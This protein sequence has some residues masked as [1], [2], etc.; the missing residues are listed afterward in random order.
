MAKR[1]IG[2]DVMQGIAMVLVVLGHHRFDF[3]PEWYMRMF[4]WIYTFHMPLFIFI[5]GFLI[6]Y[7]YKGVH[8]WNEY[9]QYVGKRVRKFLPPYLIVGSICTLMAWDF[10]D[11]GALLTSWTYLIISPKESEVT[12]L[13]YIY[14][15]LFFYCLAPLIFNT[16]RWVRG[17]L[18]A[19]AFVMSL[20]YIPI[21]YLCVDWFTRYFIFFL[22]GTVVAEHYTLVERVDAYWLLLALV[23]FIAMSIAHFRIG[24][25]F[26]LEYA[27]QWMGIPAFAAVAWLLKQWIVTRTALVYVSVNCFGV[28]LL[29]MFFVQAGA[30]VVAHLPWTIPSWGYVIYLLISAMVSIGATAW[31]WSVM[32]R[33]YFNTSPK[34]KSKLNQ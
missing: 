34:V 33:K 5:S 7:S 21:P 26:V 15:L 25:N 30:M 12:F 1:L 4:Y 18:I 14:L 3:M 17:V 20:H 27:M 16:K 19:A 10:K 31:I 11:V 2:I 32:Q 24:Y 28:Y 8:G 6:R 23:V 29:H 9:R 13:W 22:F